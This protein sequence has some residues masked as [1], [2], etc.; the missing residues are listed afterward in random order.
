MTIQ[1]SDPLQLLPYQSGAVTSPGKESAANASADLTGPQQIAKIGEP[2]PIVFCRRRN[3][4]GGVFVS[5]KATEAR[6]ENDVTI[7]TVSETYDSS[8]NVYA[9]GS[10]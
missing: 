3:N 1:V 7:V 10:M 4:N 2:V 6:Y 9:H 5:P 8:G